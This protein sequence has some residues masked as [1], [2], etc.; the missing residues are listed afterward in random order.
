MGNGYRWA[1]AAANK[2]APSTAQIF[3]YEDVGEGFFGGVSAAQFKDDLAKIGAVD[4]IDLHINSF[5]GD[6]F[7][8]LA[9]YRLL[10]D[11]KA[12]VVSF[13]D[14]FAASIASVIAMA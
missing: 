14:G 12:K 7:D 2:N 8:G 6:V 11:N 4:Q 13:I 10:V 3:I 5:G 1:R 9:I